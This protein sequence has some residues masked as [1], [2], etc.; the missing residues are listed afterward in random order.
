ML[1]RGPLHAPGVALGETWSGFGAGA[2]L[3]AL[4]TNR[5]R[6]W[7]ARRAGVDR[8]RL[9]LGMVLLAGAPGVAVAAVAF[10]TGGMLYAPFVPVAY[11]LVQSALDPAEQQPVVTLW[12]RAAPWHYCSAWRWV[13]PLVGLLGDGLAVGASAL[14]TLLLAP[15][16]AAALRQPVP[17]AGRRRDRHPARYRFSRGTSAG[18]TGR[19]GCAAPHPGRPPR[20]GSGSAGTG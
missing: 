11:S 2:L 15:V 17:V 19:A 18:P 20:R 4:A 6:R 16:A 5:L 13:A 1:V 10:G 3:G 8:R 14:A 7:P 12:G 9:G